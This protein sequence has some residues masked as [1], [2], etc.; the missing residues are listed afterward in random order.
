MSLPL[1]VYIL[2]QK[3]MC[4]M[5]GA[6]KKEDARSLAL[7]HI[8][9]YL[10]QRLKFPK[11]DFIEWFSMEDGGKSE[12]TLRRYIKGDS[13]MKKWTFEQ[14]WDLV[15]RTV[16]QYLE[17]EDIGRSLAPHAA[18]TW[19]REKGEQEEQCRLY[20]LD[21]DDPDRAEDFPK[22]GRELFEAAERDKREILEALKPVFEVLAPET[23]Y[24]L[25]RNFPALA[26]VTANDAVFLAHIMTRTA[27]EKEDLKAAMLKGATVDAGTMLA[28]L[29]SEEVQCWVNLKND[30]YKDCQRQ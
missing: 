20:F 30:D 26:A 29:Q 25:Q 28:Y 19:E 3:G 23:A 18:E 4:K 22:A 2:K 5:S 21:M 9:N 13:P 14:F 16:Q 8:A 17:Y 6:K 1:L 7:Y 11:A 24:S 27:E 12:K 15:E 10:E